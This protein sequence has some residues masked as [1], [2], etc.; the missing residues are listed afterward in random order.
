[1]TI[2]SRWGSKLP[3]ATTVVATAALLLAG[4]G[5]K[6]AGHPQ[7]TS[8]RQ[9]A[10]SSAPVITPEPSAPAT[11]ALPTCNILAWQQNVSSVPGQPVPTAVGAD[12][13]KVKYA[14]RAADP[15]LLQTSGRRLKD[16]SLVALHALPP[17][18]ARK[19]RRDY[20]LMLVF[21]GILGASLYLSGID[22]NGP[23]HDYQIAAH[24][25]KHAQRFQNLVVTQENNLGG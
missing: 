18:C 21:Y 8:R 20:R 1:M 6:V 3:A 10:V 25:L 4:C 11:Q 19:L 24:A 15:S 14:I 23:S 13:S 2:G 17:Q 9:A 16:D 12:L 5:S 7:A 22:P